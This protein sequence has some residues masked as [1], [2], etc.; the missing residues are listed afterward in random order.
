MS[1]IDA[2]LWYAIYTKPNEEERAGRNL[3]A[4]NVKTFLPKLKEGSGRRRGGGAGA[5]RPL[6]PR[7]IFARFNASSLLH[8]VNYTRGICGVVGFGEG[9]CPVDDF[10]IEEIQ[11]QIDKDGF[12]K[13]DEDFRSGDDVVIKGGPFGDCRGTVE[14]EDNWDRVTV[15]L[16]SVSYQSR[17][18]IEKA[19]LKKVAQS[20][21]SHHTV[22]S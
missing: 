16:S 10:I 14:S 8:K 11:S 2:P 13:L 6:F 18:M 7:Y 19:M 15:L 17:L 20:S 5:D 3:N 9:P 12:V 1:T 4:W 22:S 21:K